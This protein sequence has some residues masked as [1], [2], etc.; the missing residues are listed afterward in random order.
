M[1][2]AMASLVKQ[3]LH[4]FHGR[5]FDKLI[6]TLASGVEKYVFFDITACFELKRKKRLTISRICSKH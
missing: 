3:Q 5:H 1:E 2:A 4:K 6:F